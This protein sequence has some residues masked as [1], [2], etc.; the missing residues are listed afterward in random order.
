M[1]ELTN[2]R[3]ACSIRVRLAVIGLKIQWVDQ[4]SSRGG[5]ERGARKAGTQNGGKSSLQT[6]R[7]QRKETQFKIL[8]PDDNVFGGL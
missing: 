7:L 2:Q 4:S 5:V 3:E 1:K 8:K 6:T